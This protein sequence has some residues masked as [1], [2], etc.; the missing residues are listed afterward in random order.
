M[1]PEEIR[2]N[3]QINFK[4]TN[5]FAMNHGL[6]LGIISIAA[7]ASFV[8]SFSLALLSYLNLILF[9]SVPLVA[10]ALTFRFRE[11]VARDFPFSFSR[12]FSHTLLVMLYAAVWAG[13][14]TFVYLYFFDHGYL[15]DAYEAHLGRPEVVSAMQKSGLEMQMKEATGG[16]TPMQLVD[17]L[18]GIPAGSY[19]AMVVYFYLLTAPIVALLGGFF[20]M[21]RATRR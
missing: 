12:G 7:L 19:A 20:A 14:A 2:Q 11:S 3:R 6:L 4:Q 15:F 17:E 8:G 9:L 5:A 13:M 1:T 18:R 21:R 16:K 10:I